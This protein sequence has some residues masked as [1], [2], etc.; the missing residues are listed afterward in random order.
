MLAA[1]LV[2]AKKPR[3][4]M[5]QWA[6]CPLPHLS[7]PPRPST[8]LVASL[9]VESRRKH[10]QRPGRLGSCARKF[11]QA[12]LRRSARVAACS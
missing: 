1:D 12:G 4:P 5:R 6:V 3:C 2:G 8:V 11:G 10:A 7:A 9:E